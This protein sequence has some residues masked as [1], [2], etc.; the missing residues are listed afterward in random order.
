MQSATERNV[1][2]KLE[3]RPQNHRR[4]RRKRSLGA[5]AVSGSIRAKGGTGK[6][7]FRKENVSGCL[8]RG[9]GGNREL[10]HGLQDPLNERM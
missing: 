8:Y 7:R 10:R 6:Y 4:E 5:R 2:P 9:F 3:H 1:A